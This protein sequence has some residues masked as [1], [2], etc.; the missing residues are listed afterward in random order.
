M[1]WFATYGHPDGPQLRAVFRHDPSTG[2][3]YRINDDE[4]AE[5][6]LW[7]CGVRVYRCGT[8]DEMFVVRGNFVYTAA[9]HPFGTESYPWYHIRRCR[10][11]R[12]RP[13]G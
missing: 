1:L 2:L 13:T 7:V 10:D 5:P 12:R 9:G 4:A 6:V 8:M 11:R 3:V